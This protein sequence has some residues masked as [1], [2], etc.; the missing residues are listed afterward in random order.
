MHE[1]P[2]DPNETMRDAPRVPAQPW[3]PP[4]MRRDAALPFTIGNALGIGWRA[5]CERYGLLLGASAL[6][7]LL[8]LGGK[9]AAFITSLFT[10]LPLVDWAA[11]FLFYPIILLG[12]LDIGYRCARREQATASD[13]FR[14]FGRYW[15]VVGASAIAS[16]A[17]ALV[18]WIP[19]GLVGMVFLVLAVS[20]TG[21][22]GAFA[23]TAALFT[24]ALILGLLL[25][26]VPRLMFAPMVCLDTEYRVSGPWESVKLSWV[27]TRRPG[28]RP[29]LA[30][31]LVLGWLLGVAC[32]LLLL[33][34]VLFLAL[35]LGATVFGACYWQISGAYWTAREHCCRVCEYDLR[36]AKSDRCPECGAP[37]APEQLGYTGLGPMRDDG[38]ESGGALGASGLPS[39]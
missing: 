16:I 37:V 39:A 34:P 20:G 3:T 33:L 12:L 27:M 38:R 18:V 23:L 24:M 6:Y 10:L 30:A 2:T 8:F 19:A 36:D 15:P 25:V 4:E 14:P 28:V 5:M 22:S 32:V 7:L 1:P 13:L 26:L 31:L 35:P 11:T 17:I 21:Q 29:R 9:I